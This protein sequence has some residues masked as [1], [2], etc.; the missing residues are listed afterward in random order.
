EPREQGEA[1]ALAGKPEEIV[2]HAHV[3]ASLADPVDLERYQCLKQVPG[4]FL[5]ASYIV[6]NKD[7]EFLAALS[8]LVYHFGDGPAAKGAFREFLGGAECAPHIAA[9]GGVYESDSPNVLRLGL[10]QIEARMR[11]FREISGLHVAVDLL[12]PT[13]FKIGE[14]GLP[15]SEC[16]AAKN[17]ISMV[18]SILGHQ[19]R[20]EA[21]QDD[22]DSAAAELACYVISTAR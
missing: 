17:R 13:L 6:V 22:R 4:V 7:D 15:D 18:Q 3:D 8:D 20:M 14:D 5:A 1:A 21:A 11:Y 9:S 2:V 19:G 10:E 12:E 16:L